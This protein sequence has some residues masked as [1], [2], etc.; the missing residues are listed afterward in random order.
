M[1]KKEIEPETA[2]KENLESESNH[3]NTSER[4]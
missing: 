2:A 4:S 1:S 3:G